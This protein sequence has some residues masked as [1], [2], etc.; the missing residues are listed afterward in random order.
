MPRQCAQAAHRASRQ[1]FQS[2][3]DLFILQPQQQH[4]LHQGQFGLF[5]SLLALTQIPGI[6][7]DLVAIL[8]ACERGLGPAVVKCGAISRY[9]G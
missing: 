8:R 9:R 6:E 3:T 2:S 5:A 7:S 4:F 1:Y